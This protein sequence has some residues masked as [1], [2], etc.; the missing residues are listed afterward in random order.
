MDFIVVSKGKVERV[1]ETKMCHAKKYY[2]LPTEREQFRRIKTFCDE[3]Q[4]KGEL[5]IKYPSRGWSI[6]YIDNYI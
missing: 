2:P 3:H 4:V 5:H 6:E 1:I